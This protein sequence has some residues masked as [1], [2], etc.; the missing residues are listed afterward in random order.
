MTV[1]A[2]SAGSGK[3]LLVRSWLEG[4]GPDRRPAW[5]SVERGE[6]DSQHFWG[7]VVFITLVFGG[8]LI[9]GYSG[10]HRRLF[11]PF[12]YEYITHLKTLNRWT[13]FFAFGLFGTQAAFVVNFFYSIFAG[14]K[15]TGAAGEE[16]GNPWEV[17]TLDWT[18][19]ATPPVYHNFDIVPT[20]VRGPHEYANPE[21]K[22]RLG[23][24]YIDQVEEMPDADDASKGSPLGEPEAVGAE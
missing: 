22:K 13:S 2:A 10:Q 12:Q 19:T 20:V 7:A 16:G 9:A 11:N 4:S 1:V 23:R 3:T 8:Q 18:H 6:R 17:T 15:I 5:V 21:V 24:D 14:K